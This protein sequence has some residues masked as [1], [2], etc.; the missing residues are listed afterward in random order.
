MTVT[1]HRDASA[2]AEQTVPLPVGELRFRVHGHALLRGSGMDVRSLTRLSMP[3][4]Y[5][6]APEADPCAQQAEHEHALEAGLAVLREVLA[7]PRIRDAIGISNPGYHTIAFAEGKPLTSATPY[8]RLN[9][10]G[11]RHVRTGHRY[12]RRLLAKTETNSYFGPTLAVTW[13]PGIADAVRTDPPGLETCVIGLSHWVTETLARTLRR[14]CA[15]ADRAW[16]RD[17]MWRYEDARLRSTATGK[18]VPLDRVSAAVWQALSDPATARQLGDRLSLEPGEL[19]AALRLLRPALRPWP[20]PPATLSDGLRWLE[21]IYPGRSLLARLSHLT[22]QAVPESD[23]LQTRALIR[24]V[25]TEAGVPTARAPGQHY[26][27][28]DAVTEDRASPWSGHVRLGQ[29]AVASVQHALADGL[30]LLFLAA[31]L[32][33][34]DARE[35]V[36]RATGSR[37]TDLVELAGRTITPVTRRAD[38]L[39]ATLDALVPDRPDLPEI[40]L[41]PEAV[42]EAVR[43]LWSGLEPGQAD[44]L[45]CLP[46]VDLMSAGGMPGHGRWVLSECH[47]DSSS[48]LGGITARVQ[49]TGRFDEFGRA[50]TGWLDT[51]RMA[52]VIGRRRSRHITPELPGLRIELSG[53]AAAPRAR[54]APAAEVQVSADASRLEYRGRRYQLYPGDVP[55]PLF[56]ALSLPCV[57]P[58]SV[59]SDRPIGPRVLLGSLVL[60]RA[61]WRVPLPDLGTRFDAWRAARAWQRRWGMPDQIFLRHPDEPKPLYVDLLDALGVE[62]LSR[63]RPADVSCTEVLPALSDTWWRLPAP[64]PAELRVPVFVRWDPGTGVAR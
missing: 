29:P 10:R 48:A 8:T 44:V 58:V 42:A 22:D 55:G 11:R 31:M 15:P 47:D 12:L 18:V 28:R 21:E 14:E 27:D 64:Q 51:D 53:V 61:T 13:D 33:Q 50:V 60:Q 35:A 43:S 6:D 24:S 26:A 54:T 45:A 39:A 62:D 9:G 32:R 4:P 5:R 49:P 1:G 34:A 38:E 23:P 57:V 36:R 41:D 16:R 63:L 46:G 19:V 7:E 3:T 59:A 56:T 37:A 17:P 2:P 30:P 20:E 25:L 52:T 40:T